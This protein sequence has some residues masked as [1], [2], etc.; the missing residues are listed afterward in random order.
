M[1][2]VRIDIGDEVHASEENGMLVSYKQAA[3]VY[4]LTGV[5]GYAL[6]AAAVAALEAFSSAYDA[7]AA[8]TQ[9]TN[10]LLVRRDVGQVTREITGAAVVKI[11]LEWIHESRLENQFIFEGSV[12]MA[13]YE[14][15]K[16]IYG[17]QITVEHT[18]P[19]DDE[20][21]PGLLVTQGGTVKME[22][23]QILLTATGILTVDYPDRVQTRWANALNATWW[24]DG[25]P[26]TWKCI[27]VDFR[28]YDSANYK[29]LFTFSF[30][31]SYLGYE[32]QVTFI[33]K[34]TNKPP[35]GL[36]DGAGY[37]QIEAHTFIDFREIF[38]IGT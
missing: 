24:V 4:G 32:P 3:L 2:T 35:A 17:E 31:R 7:F 14:T 16:D 34:R 37:K 29:W 15:M 30:Q 33:D 18:F 11:N 23:P 8:H 21:Y 20:N 27:R 13:Q 5:S 6:G 1:A 28:P 10:L 26:G 19:D 36:V 22:E 38:N 12:R 9:H 25:E